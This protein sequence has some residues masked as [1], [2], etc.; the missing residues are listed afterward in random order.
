MHHEG[1][2]SRAFPWRYC[3]LQS[4]KL[5]RIYSISIRNTFPAYINAQ[6][7]SSSVTIYD[8]F[9]R[10][11][12]ELLSFLLPTLSFFPHLISLGHNSSES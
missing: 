12:A 4:L 6:R 9:F 2:R 3:V 7:W 8:I 11:F 10:F 1:K 5:T